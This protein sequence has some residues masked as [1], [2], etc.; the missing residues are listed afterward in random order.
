MSFVDLKP[1]FDARMKAV[2][3]DFRRWP[4]AFNI[5][6]IP[7]GILD[8]SFH[9]EVGP[10][11]Y[12]GTA[13]TCLHFDCPVKLSVFL[14]GYRDPDKQAVDSALKFADAIVKESCKG[15]NRLNQA[16]IKNVLPTLIDVRAL[17]QG[18]DNAAVLELTFSCEVVIC[19]E[20]AQQT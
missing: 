18:N 5:Q 13:H 1:Y 6:N 11:S 19:P 4:D 8:K 10:F 17:A 16:T 15:L 20:Q 12:T 3:T 2:H 14:K 7:S 9:I